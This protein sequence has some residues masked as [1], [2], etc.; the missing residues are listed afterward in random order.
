MKT[1]YSNWR[2][3]LNEA[4]LPP[5]TPPK[6]PQYGLVRPSQP[7]APATTSSA[8]SPTT[9]SS[10]P[11][12]Q[13]VRDIFTQPTRSGSF[14][15]Q[16]TTGV[17]QLSD[18]NT[19]A[20]P[21]PTTSPRSQ[22]A[23]QRRGWR[24]G[25]GVPSQRQ[26][27]PPTTP[28]PTTPQPITPPPTT[29]P[30]SRQPG[31]RR[32]LASKVVKR[33]PAVPIVAAATDITTQ[34][35]SAIVPALGGLTAAAL[36]N[37]AGGKITKRLGLADKFPKVM[38]PLTRTSQGVTNLGAY[39]YGKTLTKDVLRKVGFRYEQKTFDQF[40]VECYQD[41]IDEYHTTVLAESMIE[42]GYE[43]STLEEMI[44]IAES[45]SEEET[46]NLMEFV[47]T[48]MKGAKGVAM[49]GLKTYAPGVASALTGLDQVTSGRLDQEVM[50][51]TAPQAAKLAGTLAAYTPAGMA[52]GAGMAAH[53]AHQ[54]NV[55]R[56][57][58]ERFNKMS[59]AEKYLAGYN[60]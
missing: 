11:W 39:D 1:K 44:S 33:T 8:A 32:E 4:A 20:T 49:K 43:F 2:Q 53:D 3:E 34:G 48:L 50:K 23:A 25:Q 51:T 41:K 52:I 31:A 24:P 26:P 38:G 16:P 10:K 28:Q 46:E 59:D 30:N 7:S 42:C 55:E 29:P 6:K 12:W 14:Q 18:P 54:K 36:T 47:G 21:Q 60:Q 40:M 58:K 37:V 15:Q 56:Q 17:V 13:S 9:A 35:P 45:L 5:A 27:K 57:R 19:P 22:E